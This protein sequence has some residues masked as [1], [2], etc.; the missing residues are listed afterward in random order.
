MLN[1]REE[2]ADQRVA[3][4]A[5]GTYRVGDADSL[6]RREVTFTNQDGEHFIGRRRVLEDAMKMAQRH[7]DLLSTFATYEGQDDG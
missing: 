4:T 6:G 3:D 5:S 2:Y 7:A 1:W